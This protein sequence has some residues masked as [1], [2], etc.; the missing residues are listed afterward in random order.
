MVKD[1]SPKVVFF[2]ETQ[3]TVS[4]LKT[5]K[6]KLGFEGCFGVELVGKSG[7]LAIFWKGHIQFEVHNFSLRHISGW[8]VE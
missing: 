2:M 5:V 7:G 1:K 8:I 4:K 6:R 3:L